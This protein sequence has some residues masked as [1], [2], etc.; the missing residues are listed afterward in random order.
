[1]AHKINKNKKIHRSPFKSFYFI[2]KSVITESRLLKCDFDDVECI[3]HC[4]NQ[5]DNTFT[6]KF[7]E[8]IPGVTKKAYRFTVDTKY[9]GHSS[10]Q[11]PEKF[12][13][14]ANFMLTNIYLNLFNGDYRFEAHVSESDDGCRSGIIYTSS[15]AD[16]S[17]GVGRF[18]TYSDIKSEVAHYCERKY[19]AEA[20]CY[21][22]DET[23][24]FSFDKDTNLLE[25]LLK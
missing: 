4:N 25:L 5:F 15:N 11:N 22:I 12:I 13:I 14:H 3:I 20:G 18:Q 17:E 9:Y 1:M 24:R 2:C 6:I 16:R 19:S 7:G 23:S 21:E 10:L 8:E